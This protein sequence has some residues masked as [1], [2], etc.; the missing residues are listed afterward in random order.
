MKN[1][2]IL[3]ISIFS[4][5]LVL[6]QV[7]TSWRYRFPSHE[8]QFGIGDPVTTDYFSFGNNRWFNHI[9]DNNWFS[10][11]VY[12]KTTF[13]T[14]AISASYLYRVVKWFSVGGSIS[15]AGSYQ[16]KYDK[17]T[18]EKLG[19]VNHNL[20]TFMPYL[21]FSWFNRENV[22]LYSGIGYGMTFVFIKNTYQPEK[23]KFDFTTSGQF[24]AI[25]VTAGRKWFG[26][27]E[28]GFGYRGIISAGFGYKFG[29]R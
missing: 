29:T 25:G 8:V 26:Y 14:P 19:N 23:P 28:L 2:L 13:Y 15:F 20:L 18:D 1:I 4:S 27:A 7:D 16:Q 5:Q 24:T 21:R 11:D 12:N 3:F 22:T 9:S 17:I 6:G 10:P